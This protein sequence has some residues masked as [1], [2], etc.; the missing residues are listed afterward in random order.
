MDDICYLLNR[1]QNL[2]VLLSTEKDIAWEQFPTLDNAFKAK[3]GLFGE[4][5]EDNTKDY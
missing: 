5:P 1:I 4:S 2:S 3:Y